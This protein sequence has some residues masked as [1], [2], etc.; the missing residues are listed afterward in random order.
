MI[1]DNHQLVQVLS[2]KRKLAGPQGFP[3]SNDNLMASVQLVGI[4]E[5]LTSA[6]LLCTRGVGVETVPSYRPTFETVR[7]IVEK[8][9]EM[10]QNRTKRSS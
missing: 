1:Q 4:E 8:V 2:V 9:R 3:E 7:E 6:S 10:K 5:N